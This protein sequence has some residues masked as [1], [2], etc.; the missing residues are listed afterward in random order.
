VLNPVEAEV[1]S[2]LTLVDKDD[3]PLTAVSSLPATAY[4]W[5]PLMASVLAAEIW[6]AATLVT[7]RSAPAEPTLTTPTGA[8]P[9][10]VPN[11]VLPT[12]AE[13]TGTAA[14][15][16]AFAP[17]ATEL[18]V[19]A[20]ALGPIATASVPVAFES[21]PVELAWKYLMPWLL[22]LSIAEP[23]LLAVA[24]VPFAL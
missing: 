4:N 17:S 3:I 7:W 5:L 2:E 20:T 6:P 15:V 23:T 10:N 11:V 21:A 22:M 24:V 19:A 9:A 1:D 13:L 8:L 14:A 18:F 12:V 16:T